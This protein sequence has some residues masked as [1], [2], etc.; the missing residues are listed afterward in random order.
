MNAKS[1]NPMDEYESIAEFLRDYYRYTMRLSWRLYFS[2]Y[3]RLWNPVAFI[4]RLRLFALIRAIPISAISNTEYRK[5]IARLNIYAK[6]SEK[7]NPYFSIIISDQPMNEL[8][9]TLKKHFPDSDFQRLK[10]INDWAVER[11]FR[12]TVKF[13]EIFGVFVG[14]GV[15]LLSNIPQSVVE[16]F[17]DYD[18]Y[19]GSVFVVFVIIFIYFGA[20][21]FPTW[22]VQKI[23]RTKMNFVGDVINFVIMMNEHHLD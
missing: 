11:T 18:E 16:E 3:L 12:L 14:L 17:M 21:L 5:D 4:R 15:L 23:E 10:N 9:L 1:I 6:D 8:G 20:L 13:K 19:Q 2:C 22:M 7:N